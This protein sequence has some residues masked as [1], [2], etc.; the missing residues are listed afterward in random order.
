MSLKAFKK[1]ATERHQ[2]NSQE[3]DRSGSRTQ[4]LKTGRK[5]LVTRDRPK[6]HAGGGSGDE[7]SLPLPSFTLRLGFPAQNHILASRSLHRK[8]FGARL[9]LDNTFHWLCSLSGSRARLKRRH[10]KTP[11]T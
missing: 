4:P 3:S 7:E 8:T 9:H 10:P 5:L 1:R 11:I 2:W 6:R